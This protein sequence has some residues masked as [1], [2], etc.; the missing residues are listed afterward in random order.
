MKHICELLTLPQEVS[1][2]SHESTFESTRVSQF[3]GISLILLYLYLCWAQEILALLDVPD[4]LCWD[5][6]LSHT[7]QA[8]LGLARALVAGCSAKATGQA[9]PTDPIRPRPI[10]TFFCCT[11]LPCPMMCPGVSFQ[12]Y[13]RHRH[14]PFGIAE[15]QN[16]QSDPIQGQNLPDGSGSHQEPC[17]ESRSRIHKQGFEQVGAWDTCVVL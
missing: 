9:S 5:Q 13:I 1:L 8:K 11:N 6:V 16:C 7:Q 12:L 2:R 10:L 15:L 17:E 4:K 14:R 3:C